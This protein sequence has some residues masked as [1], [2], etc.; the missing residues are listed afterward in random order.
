M[1]DM[2]HTWY[3]LLIMKKTPKWKIMKNNTKMEDI[4]V[5]CP[6]IINDMS[7]ESNKESPLFKFVK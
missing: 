6:R 1:V 7:L 4:Q 2:L 5:T 3:D